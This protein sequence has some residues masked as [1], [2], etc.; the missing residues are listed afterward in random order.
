LL[1]PGGKLGKL[2]TGHFQLFA[3][4]CHFGP[5]FGGAASPHSLQLVNCAAILL[6]CLSALLFGCCAL[7]FDGLKQGPFF[8]R[9]RRLD[10]NILPFF[11]FGWPL[12]GRGS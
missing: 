10:I 1:L 6:G 4:L 9:R 2:G 7:L 12:S 5:G 11:P 3:H 8:V